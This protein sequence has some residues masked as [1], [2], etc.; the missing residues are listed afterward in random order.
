MRKLAVLAAAL[1]VVACGKKD[2]ANTTTDSAGAAMAPAP[3]GTMSDTAMGG[4][5]GNM[6]ATTSTGGMTGDTAMRHDTAGMSKA[7]G[8]TGGK[9]GGARGGDTANKAG[10]GSA[11]NQT[12]SGVVNKRGASTLGSDVK[13]TRPDQGQPVTSKGDTVTKAQPPR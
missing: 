12:Q 9:T 11:M 7:G 1:A 2:E 13:K 5:A 8:T 10:P 3:A 6:G 4:A